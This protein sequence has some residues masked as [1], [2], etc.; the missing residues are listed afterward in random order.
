M[1]IGDGHSG[2]AGV[3]PGG[4]LTVGGQTRR[5]PRSVAPSASSSAHGL[6]AAGCAVLAAVTFALVAQGGFFSRG[7][8]V[9]AVLVGGAVAAA[10]ARG[11]VGVEDLKRPVVVA[12]GL[13]ALWS[14]V[15]AAGAGD[16]Q[17]GMGITALLAATSATYLVARSESMVARE[18]L[19]T[20]VLVVGVG[21]AMS[22]WLG[23]VLRWEP[24]AIPTA[25]VWRA[26]TV[27]TYA[28]SASAVLVMFVLVALG[29]LAAGATA[30]L[31]VLTML[32]LVG[33]AATLSRAGGV[34]LVIGL[35]ALA[36]WLGWA[37]LLAA[38]LAP[39]V[40]AGVA[41]AGLLPS[42]PQSGAAQPAMA[43]A[44][45]VAGVGV[46]I[47]LSA[48]SVSPRVGGVIIAAAVLG[49][50]AVLFASASDQFS[51]RLSLMPSERISRDAA[52]LELFADEPLIGV[53]PGPLWL[54]WEDPSGRTVGA[55]FVH[56]EY[57]QVLAQLGAVGALLIAAL[58]AF[59]ARAMRRDRA[60]PLRPEVWAGIAAGLI[61]FAVH[62]AFDFLWHV[63]AIPLLAAV[64]IGA[65]APPMTKE[66][67][68]AH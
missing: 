38:G 50:A 51:E 30:R 12:S 62:S 1:L 15:R 68:H 22:G 8:P 63:P 64:L 55:W 46:T 19:I 23:V 5:W 6:S 56:N 32:L 43:I 40:G 2:T 65:A 39:V 27:I 21:V 58:L 20:A 31:S 25:G 42:L 13:V 4:M 44:A 7:H 10:V 33:A 52:A 67:S 37:R 16:I 53:G 49:L 54:T 17:M 57:L 9:L 28:N 36:M 66:A 18:M 60:S 34:A 14:L 24:L 59:A 35:A 48:R 61:A 45:L 3:G 11:A 26:T 41:F 47:F 29:R